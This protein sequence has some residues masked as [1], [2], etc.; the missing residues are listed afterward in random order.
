MRAIVTAL[1]IAIA[2]S[3][4]APPAAKADNPSDLMAELTRLKAE[5]DDLLKQ[6][7]ASIALKRK[8]EQELDRLGQE[9]NRLKSESSALDALKPQVQRL[10]TGD[11]PADQYA[12]AVAR[13]NSVLLPY[14]ARVK[15]FNT[16]LGR[17]KTDYTTVVEAEHAR[18]VAAQALLDKYDRNRQRIDEI[19]R[20]ILTSAP[21]QCV[22]DRHCGDLDREA[23]VA[24]LMSCWDGSRF[25][26]TTAGA[27]P[28]VPA[29]PPASAPVGDAARPAAIAAPA[30]LRSIPS[31]APSLSRRP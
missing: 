6:R 26:Q 5:Q 2:A 1:A 18:A 16:D 7:D 3:L 11:V 22:L 17:W 28:F 24:C 29:P 21:G 20:I 8:H 30:D 14:N 19:R 9:S 13:C 4:L 10:C 23:A 31:I 12:A 25:S 15:T 27:R